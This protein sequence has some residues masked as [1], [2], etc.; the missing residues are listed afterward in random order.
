MAL[1]DELRLTPYQRSPPLRMR[2]CACPRDQQGCRFR[3]SS[4]LSRRPNHEG[5]GNYMPDADWEADFRRRRFAQLKEAFELSPNRVDGQQLEQHRAVERAKVIFFL[6]AF[7][8]SGDLEILR[9][10]LDSWSKTTGKGFGF[11][12]ANGQMYLNQL[13]KD[14][15]A[16]G[17]AARLT[18]WLEPPTSEQEAAIRINELAAMT[19]EMRKQGSAAQVGRAPF[20]LSWLW[21]IQEPTRW[22]SIWP[23]RENQLVQLGFEQ[24]YPNDQQGNGISSICGYAASLVPTWSASWCS[25]G[26][27]TIRRL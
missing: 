16:F 2:L 14:G 6:G 8:A 13:S 24:G 12:G 9:H 15:A 26:S 10:S 23:S 5:L 1:P 20:L 17:F 7:K 3:G 22:M 4:A 11:Q 21:W 25:R 18:E 27:G 19:A